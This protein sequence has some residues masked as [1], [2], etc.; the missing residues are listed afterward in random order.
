M[1][2]LVEGNPAKEALGVDAH[3]A[4]RPGQV[5]LDEKKPR[6]GVGREQR[7][8]E[9][10]EHPLGHVAHHQADLRREGRARGHA[11]RTRERP[12]LA[13]PVFRAWR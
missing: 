6:L 3:A 10:A 9:L 5:G 4:N 11:E 13:E 1:G 12:R 7:E 2:D 8:L